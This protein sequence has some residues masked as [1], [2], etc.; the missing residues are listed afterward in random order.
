MRWRKG[1]GSYEEAPAGTPSAAELFYDVYVAAMTEQNYTG[2][3]I[4]IAGHSLGNQMVVCLAKLVKDG[5]TAGA[6][7]ERLRPTRIAL[8][9]LY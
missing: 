9:D 6:V 5:I 8:L 2:G 3:N 7:P 1:G 4:R